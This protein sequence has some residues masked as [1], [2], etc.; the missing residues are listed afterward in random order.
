M[1]SAVLKRAGHEVIFFDTSRF[2]EE[3]D[4]A[5]LFEKSFQ[6]ME[7]VLQFLPVDLPPVKKSDEFVIAALHSRIKSFNPDL[8]GFS[9]TSSEFP[10]LM[11]IIEEIKKYNIPTVVGG[12]HATVSPLD[13]LGIDGIDMV[14]VGEGEEAILEL[15][16]AME[17]GRPRTDIRNVYFKDNSEVIQNDIRPYINN[18][19]SLPFMDLDIFD[20]YHHLGAYQGQQ[21][22][23]AR[24]E[25]GRGCPYK[26]TYCVNETLHDTIYNHE[27]RHVRHKSPKRVI[28]E[29]RFI[30]DETNFD[31]VR[32][33]DE[34]F[35]ACS[36]EWL[37]EFVKLYK[38]EINKPMII[39]TRPERV[40]R[41]KMEVLRETH[42][43]IQ[44]TMGIE[45]GS[46]RIRRE[47]LNRR[48]SNETIIKAYKLCHELGF[49][50]AAFNMIGL[51]GEM[52][53]DFFETIQLNIEAKVQTPI[54]SYFYPFPGCKLRDVCIREGYI[55]EELHE[56]DYSTSPVLKLPDFP[57][58]EI[59]GLKRTFVMYVK[60]D[61]SFYTEIKR[62]EQ[63]DTTFNKLVN[64]YNEK[65]LS[66]KI[67]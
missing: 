45:S 8:I 33:V 9:V 4:S 28:G 6:K 37:E 59:E 13:V 40:T 42:K 18:L 11:T 29:L 21:V 1:I 52:R 23:Y 27:R 66:A 54:L 63:D 39:A 67:A 65:L 53:E 15:T 10:Y 20:R 61:K 58:E 38:F 17:S 46:E 55:S 48:M 16:E 51:P 12:I 30:Y 3:K 5:N 49:S 19:D 43:N 44:V 24:F 62:A 36:I 64:L 50:T 26:C 35:T 34:T 31:I 56:V 47:I 41:K 22:T 60:M 14:V 25:A 7:E 32:F 57:I 2:K